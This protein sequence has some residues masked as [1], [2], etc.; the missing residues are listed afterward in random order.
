MPGGD[1]PRQLRRCCDGKRLS[2]ADAW[3]PGSGGKAGDAWNPGKECQSWSKRNRLSGPTLAVLSRTLF[4]GRRWVDKLLKVWTRD[5]VEQWLLIHVEVQTTRD[6]DLPL[7][8]Y[9]YNYRVFARY[10]RQVISLAVL[11]DDEPNWRPRQYT[12]ERW[13]CRTQEQKRGTQ[14]FNRPLE[15]TGGSKNEGAKTR[16]ELFDRSSL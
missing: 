11:A 1:H 10:N 12:T 7:R 8:L 14:L 13:G 5:G 3:Q 2:S 6:P 16:T 15:S 4:Q 9:V